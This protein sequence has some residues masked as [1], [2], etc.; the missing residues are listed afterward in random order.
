MNI[1]LQITEDD[2]K[3][4]VK[5]HLSNVLNVTLAESDIRIEVKTTQNYKAEWEVGKFRA[6]VIKSVS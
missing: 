1:Q 3:R 2:L 4:L 6:T 5:E